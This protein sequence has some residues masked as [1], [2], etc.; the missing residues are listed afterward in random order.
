MS[1]SPPRS[2]SPSPTPVGG[3]GPSMARGKGRRAMKLIE[4]PA[5]SKAS[6]VLNMTQA[7]FSRQ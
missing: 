6:F 1:T 3:N 7:E 5:N 2:S 4:A